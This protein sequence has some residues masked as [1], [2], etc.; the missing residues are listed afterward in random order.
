MRRE[1]ALPATDQALRLARLELQAAI[2]QE[3][4][5][6]SIAQRSEA[7][8]IAVTELVSNAVR[9]GALES[10]DAIHLQIQADEDRLRVDVAQSTPAEGVRVVEPTMDAE[11]AGGFGLRIVAETVDRWGH[12]IGP[13]G[14]VWFELLP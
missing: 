10:A 14:R 11:R 5:S 9:H 4:L 3:V 2:A 12:E 8:L 1:V 7:A 13:P 6:P